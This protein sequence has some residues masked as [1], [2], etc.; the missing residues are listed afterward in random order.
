MN[1]RET[2]IIAFILFFIIGCSPST[3]KDNSLA[4]RTVVEQYFNA[5]NNQDYEAMYN[6]ISDGFKSLEPTAKTLDNFV[7]YAKAQGITAVK[8]ISLEEK[9][10]DNT[11][12]TVDY[13]I[14]FLVKNNEVPF[15]GT[16]TLKYKL[17]DTVQGWKL[18]H[19]YGEHIDTS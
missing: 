3:E 15:Q 7:A 4:P 8:V 12:A 1:W 9:S 11:T 6:L 16:F 13:A 10:N 18:I 17:N 5:W 19:P 14:T 2:V